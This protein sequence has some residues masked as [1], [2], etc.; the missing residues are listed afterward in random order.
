MGGS[1]RIRWLTAD[2]YWHITGSSR[3]RLTLGSAQHEVLKD[4]AGGFFIL[5]RPLATKLP[6]LYMSKKKTLLKVSRKFWC[7]V[8]CIISHSRVSSNWK[9][10]LSGTSSTQ[11]IIIVWIKTWISYQCSWSLMSMW[12]MCNSPPCKWSDLLQWIYE[13]HKCHTSIMYSIWVSIVNYM[14]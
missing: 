6:L 8:C 13:T 10:Q 5:C 3:R 11:C 2:I 9:T 14:I 7:C 4:H 1:E 12:L